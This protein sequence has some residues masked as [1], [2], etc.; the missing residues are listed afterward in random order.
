MS[1]MEKI[2][3]QTFVDKIRQ[4]MIF[5]GVPIFLVLTKANKVFDRITPILTQNETIDS[6]TIHLIPLGAKGFKKA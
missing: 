5:H 4:V 2:I 6:D 3:N 1:D